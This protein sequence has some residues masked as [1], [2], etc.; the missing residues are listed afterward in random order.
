MLVPATGSKDSVP[1][2]A[3]GRLAGRHVR[4]EEAGELG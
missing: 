2:I 3:A 1:P 4:F